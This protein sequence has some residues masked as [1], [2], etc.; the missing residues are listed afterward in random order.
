MMKEAECTDRQ[1]DSH[2][3][4][5]TLQMMDMD[6][7]P[8]FVSVLCMERKSN[9]VHFQIPI[10]GVPQDSADLYGFEYYLW[11]RKK[12]RPFDFD[13]DLSQDIKDNAQDPV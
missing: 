8:S 9:T 2:R 1:T 10:D 7:E 5:Q 11:Q 4:W 6:H 12:T 3:S 13:E